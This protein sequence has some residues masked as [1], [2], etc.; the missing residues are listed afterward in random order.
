MQLVDLKFENWHPYAP[1]WVVV[2]IVLVAAYLVVD[3]VDSLMYAGYG[4]SSWWSWAVPSDGRSLPARRGPGLGISPGPPTKLFGV[5]E[6]AFAA[7]GVAGVLWSR[8]DWEWARVVTITGC[9][10]GFVC[11]LGAGILSFA[12]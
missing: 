9:F 5:M 10:V 6:L 12:M 4:S 1:W 8:R 3:G 2:L 7:A 11:L